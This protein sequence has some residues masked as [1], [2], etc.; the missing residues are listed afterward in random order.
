MKNNDVALIRQILAG[1]ETA[2]AELVKKYQKQVHVLA[3]RKIGDFHIAEDITQDVFLKVYQRL[4]T[5]KDLNQFSGWL[6]VITTNLCNTWL[7]KNRIHYQVSEDIETTLIE[8][9]VYSR[10]ITE[11][12][13]KT[14][15]EAQREVV[16]RLLAKL[17]ESERTVM[18][19]H[20]LAEMTVEEISKFLG[21]SAGTIK[22]RLQRARN[23]LQKE[24]TMIREALEHFKLSPNL[25]DN[26]MQEIARLKPAAPTGGKPMVPWIVAATSAVLIVLMLG[27]GSQNLVRFQQ[28]YTLDAQ[29]ETAI[30]LVDA[31][32]VLNVDMESDERNQLGNSNALDIS[33]NDGQKPEEVLLAAAQ[34]EGEDVSTPKQ[35]WIQSE[36]IKGTPLMSILGTPEGDIYVLGEELSLY[37]LPADEENWQHITNLDSTIEEFIPDPPMAKWKNTLYILPF[38][39]LYASKDDG[40][41]WDTVHS[42]KEEYGPNTLIPTE[43]AFYIG[44]LTGIYRSVDSGNTWKKID[45]VSMGYIRSL[46]YVKNTLFANTDA[47]FFRLN[48]DNWERVEFPSA[49]M[50][51]I[52]SVATTEKHIYV[53]ADFNWEAKVPVNAVPPKM[54]DRWWILRSTDLGESWEDITPT[55]AWSIKGFAPQLALI[56]IGETLM[57]IDQIMVRSTDAGD[58][59]I[60]P[61]TPSTSSSMISN[62]WSKALNKDII[63]IGCEDGLHR[64]TDNGESWHKVNIPQ[65]KVMNQIDTLITYKEH[66]KE[67]N[68]KSVIYARLSGAFGYGRGEIAKTTDKGKSWKTIQMEIPITERYEK[69]QPHISHIV[70]SGGVIYAKGGVSETTV[71]YRLSIDGNTLVPIQ[72]IP[73]F[74]TIILRMYYLSQGNH[75]HSDEFKRQVEENSFGAA[76]FY[77]QL[78]QLDTLQNE[79]L[80]RMRKRELFDLGFQG[81]FAVSN[82]T[83]YLEYNFK[84][85]RWNQGDTAW[86]DIGL[87]ETVELTEDIS[88]KNLKLAVSG[89]TVYVGKR[90]G[91]LVVSLD[92][93]NNWVD[94]TPALPFKVNVYKDIVIVGNTVYV[95]TDAGVATSDRGNN[96]GVITDP[97]GTNLVLEHLAVAEKTIYGVTID[98]GVYRLESGTWK[99]VVSEIPDHA[100]SLAVDGNT[101]F[102][103]TEN[104]EMYYFNLEE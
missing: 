39:I 53:V 56:A 58:T 96:W 85:F 30:E 33:E 15:V 48:N 101:L 16:K 64:S 3:W 28:P 75:P 103:G 78:E 6:Y 27:L 73:S 19:L 98:T 32:I 52:I 34:V 36:P 66:E 92:R 82:G 74:N 14:T 72:N 57:A 4:H 24:E 97:E 100:S 79:H 80:R 11:E 47:G 38:N 10:H 23:R 21:V 35:Q 41:T 43:N 51:S 65:E 46:V 60:S 95:A 29:A 22:S 67:Q 86:S 70:N 20:Y 63:Y 42:W 37:K 94:L 88:L 93:G 81:P 91:H 76:Q 104:N 89:N 77:K 1:D 59:W 49:T 40:K 61:Q 68:M 83:F 13:V 90:D 87:E 31:P 62:C 99:Q 25:T 18:T 54:E 2:F 26:I 44:F 45:D 12:R 8:R 17:K 9:D 55:N 7:S 50:G 71:F 102:V 69:A 5:L 84:L